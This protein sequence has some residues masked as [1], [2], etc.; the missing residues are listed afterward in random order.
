MKCAK[1]PFGIKSIAHCGNITLCS[2]LHSRKAFDMPP[3]QTHPLVTTGPRLLGQAPREGETRAER[4]RGRSHTIWNWSR[5]TRPI[6]CAFITRNE[7]REHYPSGKIG[8]ASC[9]ESV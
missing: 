9:R 4:A 5:A 1:C 6:Q 8:R 2:G 7:D 3:I